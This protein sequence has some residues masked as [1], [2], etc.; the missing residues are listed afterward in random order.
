[1]GKSGA[2]HPNGVIKITKEQTLGHV[3]QILCTEYI[4]AEKPVLFFP[5]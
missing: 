1:M 5:A 2:M 3:D 4:N